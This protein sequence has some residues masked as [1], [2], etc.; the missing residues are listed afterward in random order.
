MSFDSLDGE[1]EASDGLPVQ[2]S[3][4][5]P[6]APS[7]TAV[8]PATGRNR[9]ENKVFRDLP[10]CKGYLIRQMSKRVGE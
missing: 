8:M 9:L 6:K 3:T 1:T 5:L 4:V 7:M 10:N 2:R